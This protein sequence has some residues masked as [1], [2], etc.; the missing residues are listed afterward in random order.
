MSAEVSDRFLQLVRRIKAECEQNTDAR[1]RE[2]FDKSLVGC[3]QQAHNPTLR[4]LP[5]EYSLGR[6]C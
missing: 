4:H 5:F 2:G 3:Q 1:H 6:D